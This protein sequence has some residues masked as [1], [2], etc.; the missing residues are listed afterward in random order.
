MP[1]DRCSSSRSE[2][3]WIASIASAPPVLSASRLASR[4]GDRRLA[5]KARRIRSRP[6]AGIAG[7]LAGL[8][9]D[10]PLEHGLRVVLEGEV[11]DGTAGLGDVPRDL[12]REGRLAQ[13]L[14]TREQHQVAGAEPSGQVVV[15]DRE[16]GRPDARGPVLAVLQPAVRLFEDAGK[17][18]QL[19]AQVT[20]VTIASRSVAADATVWTTPHPNG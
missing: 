17:C 19:V 8:D 7:E 2:Y 16:A 5:S 14:G 18:L 11:D 15:E 6:T 13:T 1:L 3:V 20:H 12:Q 10:E 9:R 4:H